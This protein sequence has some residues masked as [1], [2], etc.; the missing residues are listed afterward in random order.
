MKIRINDIKFIVAA[1]CVYTYIKK[2]DYP[3]CLKLDNPLIKF[4]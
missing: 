2:R 4:N 3:S 1:L